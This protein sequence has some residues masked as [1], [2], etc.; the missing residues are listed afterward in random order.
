M[1]REVT[2]DIAP[3]QSFQ[4][5]FPINIKRNALR[6]TIKVLPPE[7]DDLDDNDAEKCMDVSTFES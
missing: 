1:T 7:S 6:Y 5:D 2:G 3:Q 4:I